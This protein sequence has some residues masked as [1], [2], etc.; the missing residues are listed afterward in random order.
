MKTHTLHAAHR[1]PAP[2]GAGILRLLVILAILAGA[3]SSSPHVFAQDDTMP[4]LGI[5]PADGDGIFFSEEMKPGKTK[6][7][8]QSSPTVAR[9]T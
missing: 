6:S 8:R 3:L 4:K 2:R 5:K 7:S 9:P 1:I